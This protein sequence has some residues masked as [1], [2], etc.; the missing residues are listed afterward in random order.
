MQR[1]PKILPNTSGSW[2]TAGMRTPSLS[3]SIRTYT[4]MSGLIPSPEHVRIPLLQPSMGCEPDVAGLVANR[5]GGKRIV[6]IH[7]RLRRLDAGYG[8]AQTYS[9]D[10]DFLDWFE[11]LKEAE[12]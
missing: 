8:A 1:T 2:R 3:I 5:F 10:S 6:A 7:I 12:K 4:P 9:R 11:F